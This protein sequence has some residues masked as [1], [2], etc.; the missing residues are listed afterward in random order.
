MTHECMTEQIV[1][2][3]PHYPLCN[4]PNI[5]P[6][7]FPFILPFSKNTEATQCYA[8]LESSGVLFEESSRVL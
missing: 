7:V 8:T 6:C 5:P 1:H 3:F 4:S 2:D